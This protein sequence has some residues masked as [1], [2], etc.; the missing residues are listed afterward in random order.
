LPTTIEDDFVIVDPRQK[1]DLDRDLM[2][3]DLYDTYL[4]LRKYPKARTNL[5]KILRCLHNEFY[6]D[7]DLIYDL[8][9]FTLWDMP[10]FSKAKITFIISVLSDNA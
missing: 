7:L 4:E 9:Q 6:T 10:S 2:I 3:K 5:K 8:R 1:V